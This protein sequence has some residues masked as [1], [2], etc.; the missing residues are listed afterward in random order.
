M[1]YDSTRVRDELRLKN[2]IKNHDNKELNDLIFTD[3]I[4]PS[5][6][7]YKLLFL[8]R[9]P[10][11]SYFYAL[12]ADDQW[13]DLCQKLIN[14]VPKKYLIGPMPN[15]GYSSLPYA[16][17]LFYGSPEYIPNFLKFVSKS[18]RTDIYVHKIAVTGL[19]RMQSV[20][21]NKIDYDY[22]EGMPI[23]TDI[24]QYQI[25]EEAIKKYCKLNWNRTK[26]YVVPE[27]N[28]F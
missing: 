1:T 5:D 25:A 4:K 17:F 27:I 7:I 26:Y 2:A 24:K 9:Y 16:D 18:K 21:S 20:I 15:N 19:T 8:N 11:T 13:I 23:S 10:R 3:L 22:P 14:I 12:Q 6:E 28:I